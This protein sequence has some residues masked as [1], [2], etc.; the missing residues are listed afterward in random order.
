MAESYDPKQTMAALACDWLRHFRL[1]FWNRWTE[2]IEIWQEIRSQRPLPCSCFGVDRKN[3]MAALGSDG[4]IHSTSPQQPPNGIQ[5]NLTRSK[6]QTSSTRLVI[7]GRSEKQ[8]GHPV[9]SVNKDGTLYTCARYL[10]LLAPCL[11]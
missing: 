4:L 2:F 9:R 3:K 11:I 1:L 5:W 10:A 8:D 6:I 7:S